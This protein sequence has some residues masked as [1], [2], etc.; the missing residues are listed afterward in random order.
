MSINGLVIT[1]R[2]R[3]VSVRRR[4]SFKSLARVALAVVLRPGWH[5]S[6]GSRVR[7]SRTLPM[8]A[9]PGIGWVGGV[10]L[11]LRP[12]DLKVYQSST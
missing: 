7:S 6:V 9:A 3:L 8:S 4:P 2:G 11:K 12:L 5:R 1:S 10:Q